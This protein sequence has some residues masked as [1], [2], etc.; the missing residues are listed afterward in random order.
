[1]QTQGGPTP[2]FDSQNFHQ[3][4][5][6]ENINVNVKANLRDTS[7]KEAMPNENG[8]YIFDDQLYK[9]RSV[10]EHVNAWIDGFKALLVRFEFSVRNWM[11]LHFMAFL[12]IFLRKIN[13][14]KFKQ[15]LSQVECR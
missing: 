12:V 10:I 14:K 13:K 7:E 9:V 1:M 3:A 4:C 15:L 6:K 8:T 11:S 5:E 2:R